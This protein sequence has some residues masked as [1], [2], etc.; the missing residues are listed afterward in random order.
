MHFGGARG[1]EEQQKKWRKEYIL[2]LSFSLF[3]FYEERQFSVA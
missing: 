3:S 2:E 1:G